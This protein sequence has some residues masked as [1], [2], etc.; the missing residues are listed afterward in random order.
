MNTLRQKPIRYTGRFVVT[1]AS[2]RRVQSCNHIQ[3]AEYVRDQG[4]GRLIWWHEG[5]GARG[6]YICRAR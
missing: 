4:R 3:D 6:R 5:A 1:T 2:G